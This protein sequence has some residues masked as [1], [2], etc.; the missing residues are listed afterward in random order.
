MRIQDKK[1]LWLVWY[2]IIDTG[3]FV[4]FYNWADNA[5]EVLLINELSFFDKPLESITL[6]FESIEVKK[7][8]EE[9]FYTREN[10]KVLKITRF[11]KDEFDELCE[12]AEHDAL[13]QYKNFPEN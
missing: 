9:L 6:N 4:F 3:K 2:Q 11:G 12:T 10:M 7:T 5:D 1:Y 13:D 8:V